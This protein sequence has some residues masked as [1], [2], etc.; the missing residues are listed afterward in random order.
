MGFNRRFLVLLLGGIALTNGLF[1]AD[2]L[3]IN[4]QQADSIF[5][6]NNYYLLASSMNVE[7]KKAQVLQAKLYPNPILTMDL[8]AY[9]PQNNKVLHIG[10]TGQKSFQL[11]QLII[12]G[13]KRKSEIEIARSNTEIAQLEFQDLVRQL[14]FRLHKNLFTL[15]QYQYLLEKYNSQLTLLDSIM[16]GYEIQVTKGNMPLKDLVRLKGVYLGLNND[17]ADLLKQYFEAQADIQ[18]LLQTNQL[19]VFRFTDDDIR[20]YIKTKSLDELKTIAQNNHPQLIL[21]RQNQNLA[22]QY[23]SYQKR[24]A[25]PDLN[26]FTAYDQ[27]GGAF[28]NQV[29]AG[30]AIP[31][32]L[33]NRN[34][35]NIKAAR[36][37]LKES[38]YDLNAKQQEIIS[39]LQNSYALYTHTIQEFEKATKLYNQ[40]FEITLKG[41]SDNFQKRNV[42][43]IEFVDFFEAYN[44]T[45]AEL[46]R[47]KSQLVT[48]AEQ[49]NLS[50]G[51]DIY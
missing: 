39:S 30:I 23:L 50:I 37:S 19:V 36:F 35:G 25:I 41:M 43:L 13:G 40:D 16:A 21:F 47:I 29:N 22:R 7:A 26:L 17:R 6:V 15:G 46:A 32:P 11:E 34:Q 49:L 4:I 8:N 31:I 24:T 45:I 44:E 48:S 12:L 33:W 20:S 2:T 27:R 9:D 18:T 10:Q 28:N 1:A 38:E 42:S 14:K 51:T 3:R 5:F